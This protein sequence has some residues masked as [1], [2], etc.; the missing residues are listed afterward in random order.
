MRVSSTDCRHTHEAVYYTY[1]TDEPDRQGI[2]HLKM[3][4]RDG[5]KRSSSHFPLSLWL[6]R[7]VRSFFHI[8]GLLYFFPLLSRRWVGWIYYIISPR[9]NDKLVF[10]FLSFTFDK[11]NLA[12]SSHYPVITF[13]LLIRLAAAS[14]PVD[15]IAPWARNSRAYNFQLKKTFNP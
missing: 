9:H 11:K 13:S 1:R 15:L 10:F 7:H 5:W 12:K 2:Y 3:I 4:I 6:P 8:Y 14:S